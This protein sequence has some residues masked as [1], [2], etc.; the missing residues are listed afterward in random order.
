LPNSVLL[1]AVVTTNGVLADKV[2]AFDALPFQ[3]LIRKMAPLAQ[4]FAATVDPGRTAVAEFVLLLAAN[5]IPVVVL[6]APRSMVELACKS[7]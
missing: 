5:V 4:A 3:L 7:K 6:L 2:N 1:R